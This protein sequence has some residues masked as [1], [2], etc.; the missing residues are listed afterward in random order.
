MITGRDSSY[1]QWIA[2]GICLFFPIGSQAEEA[3]LGLE[4]AIREA[5]INNLNLKLEKE[6]EVEATGVTTSAQSVFDTGFT[7]KAATG[8]T[9]NTPLVSG[10]TEEETAT[11]WSAALSKTFTPGTNLSFS[12][13][14]NQLENSPQTYPYD[15]VYSSGIKLTI[16]QPLMKGFGSDNQTALIR[17]ARKQEEASSL[18]VESKAADLAA[19]VKAGYWDL[20]FAWQ[21]I[22]VK[23]IS[24]KLAQKLLEETQEKIN[25]GKLADVEL[26][27]PQSEVA[28]REESLISAERTIGLAED[29]IKILLN[30]DDWNV[31]IQ[32]T[33]LP[34]VTI[35]E[36]DLETV[37]NNSLKNR[38][39]LKAAML[40]TEAT[41]ISLLHSEDKTRSS[42]SLLGSVG[43]SGTDDTY[44]DSLDN[45]ASDSD[46]SW[47]IGITFTRPL[48]NSF[49]RGELIQAEAKLNQAKTSSRILQQ[50]IKRAVRASLRDVNLAI[51]TM[52]ATK[53]T[54]LS[55]LKGLEAEQIKF[56]AGRG[57]TLDVLVAQESYATALSK[58]K[59]AKTNYAKTLAELDRIQGLITMASN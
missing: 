10:A 35:K 36:Y 15:P 6:K 18:V 31:S 19:K 50:E 5:L 2:L 56:N 39:D 16:T 12:W 25:A 22:E 27:R 11:S 32:P 30:S 37:L 51:K 7:A 1:I 57:T 46:T 26:F 58:E 29:L 34:N 52:E 43:I 8:K 59:L 44:G 23:R 21:D 33:D 48:D 53:R 41:K 14:N 4:Q 49:A 28:R 40:T 42:L 20:V 17:A 47:Q 13:K 55:T 3:T 9:E 54:S 24:L 38:P 45:L